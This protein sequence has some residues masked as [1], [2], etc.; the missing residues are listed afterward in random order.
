MFL[1][2]FYDSS[3]NGIGD[4]NG[5]I[6]KLDYFEDLGVICIFLL[7]FY[8]FFLKDDGYDVFDFKSVYFNYGNFDDFECFFEEVYK[9]G[10]EVIIDFIMNY[11]F[12]EYEWF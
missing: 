8:E 6:E 12:I 7:F 9:C 10:F 3:G 11:I 5:L 4:I 1:Y 2:V